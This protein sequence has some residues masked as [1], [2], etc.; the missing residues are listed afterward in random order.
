MGGFDLDRLVLVVCTIKT[1][2]GEL[3]DHVA[4]GYF[5]SAELVLTA[6]H[7]VTED[8]VD[9]KI[10]QEANGQW[11]DAELV[12]AWCGPELDAVLLRVTKPVKELPQ[13]E[14]YNENTTEN[15]TWTSTAYPVAAQQERAQSIE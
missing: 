11:Q 10:R 6:A 4:T 5:A 8:V 13:I 7:V 3:R 1:R 9:I 2:Q 15:V 12:P 14:W